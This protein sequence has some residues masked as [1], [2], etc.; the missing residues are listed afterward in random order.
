M[1][2]LTLINDPSAVGVSTFKENF[3]SMKIKEESII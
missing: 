1:K 2:N 3:S